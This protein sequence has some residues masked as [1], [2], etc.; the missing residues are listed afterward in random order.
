MDGSDV[1][2]ADEYLHLAFHASA[3]G[4]HHACL[5]YLKEVLSLQPRNATALYLLA[6]QHADL[7]L[8]ARAIAGMKSALAIDPGLE[9]ARFQL[10]WM[11]MDAG[12][13]AEAK[14]HFG[15][16]ATS[17][18]QAMQSYASA[19]GALADGNIVAA[20]SHIESGLSRKVGNP[21]LTN[22]MM[23]LLAKLSNAKAATPASEAGTAPAPINLGAY[24]NRS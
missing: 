9:A 11:L 10:G 22:I 3:H 19:L 13:V 15:T 23:Q 16:L 18:D 20:K 4:Q 17:A 21:G 5:S 2:D 1:L 12:A 14:T 24:G 7:G 6:T 8:H